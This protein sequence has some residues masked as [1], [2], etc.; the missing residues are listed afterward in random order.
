VIMLWTAQPIKLMKE[1]GSRSGRVFEHDRDV[2]IEIAL[3]TLPEGV[4][5]VAAVPQH[6]S[7][8]SNWTALSR[9]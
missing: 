1:S 4:L 6:T 8:P 3:A 7:H 2:V 9:R 5:T